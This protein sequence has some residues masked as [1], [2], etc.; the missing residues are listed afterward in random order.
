MIGPS[1]S[2]TMPAAATAP[3]VDDRDGALP[4]TRT[5]GPTGAQ[6]HA[7]GHAGPDAAAGPQPQPVDRRVP[8]LFGLT[9]TEIHDRYWASRGIQVIRNG[10]LTEIVEDAELFLLMAPN[11]LAIFDTYE[12]VDQLTWLKP[13][14]MWLR[15]SDAREHAYREYVS[16]SEDGRFQSFRRDYGAGDTR[17]ARV[18][19]SPNPRLAHLW[20]EAPN[21][22][23][24]WQQ[25]RRAVP[26]VR[27][28]SASV[29]GLAYDRDLPQET[30]QFL[31][32]MVGHWS[33]PDMTI[34]G[35]RR[36]A[37][38]VWAHE[39]ADVA[40]EVKYVGPSW[41]GAARQLDAQSTV[42]G[43]AVLWDAP[44][45]DPPQQKKVDWSEL[46]P[47][48]LDQVN[49]RPV[50][51]PSGVSR[52]VKRA[53][54]IVMALVGLAITLPMYPLIML[55][56]WIEDGRPFFFA[57]G[58]ETLGGREFPCMKFRSMYNNAEEVRRKL[59]EEGANG[60]DGPQ[61]FIEDDPRI[62]KV[63]NFLRKTQLDEVP[64]LFNVL[65]GHMSLVG[66]RPLPRKENQFC[67]PWRE[68]R[69]SVRPGLTGLWQVKRTRAE[70][71]D[72]QEWIRF[73]IEY[74]ENASFWL[75]LKL[76]LLTVA[77]IVGIGKNNP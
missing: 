22:R 61:F 53:F 72:F 50:R 2:Q 48:D 32:Y 57:H 51:M 67:P 1:A 5:G 39:Q 35:L 37:G 19:L 17:L 3:R 21:A 20:R 6:T 43:P 62:T 55:A 23:V 8:T 44:E 34:P 63:G 69:L 26:E 47:S 18:A 27:R 70:G 28:A 46:G 29:T 76:I 42:V 24:G 38:G 49:I 9:A 58:R 52:V 75:D 30:M 13:Q 54:D 4:H 60:V 68:A 41:I 10:E 36:L 16:I 14:V 59:L 25:L 56:I 77:Q 40:P 71:L 73:D 31:R 45:S 12:P 7:G 66:P 11:L 15:L 74:V 33:R 65:V 64:Q